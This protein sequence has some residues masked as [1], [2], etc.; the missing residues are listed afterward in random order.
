MLLTLI[1]ILA[2]C[3]GQDDEIAYLKAEIAYLQDVIA[4]LSENIA[5]LEATPRI[6]P[7]ESPV[8]DGRILVSFTDNLEDVRVFLG[9]DELVVAEESISWMGN[10]FIFAVSENLWRDHSPVEL[11]FEYRFWGESIGVRLIYY[12][13]A[14]F[15]AGYGFTEAGRPW[16]LQ[17]HMF[18]ESFVMRAIR[19]DS[20]FFE[21][22]SYVEV[23][24]EPENW[25]AQVVAH[26]DEFLGI[27]LFDV[28]YERDGR[29]VAD[30]APLCI[31]AP[32]N[33]GSTG[34]RVSTLNIIES[35]ATLPNVTEIEVL[36]G[37]QRGVEADHFSFAGVFRV[38][39]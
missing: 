39:N 20:N 27:R 7:D 26:F 32:W 33:W 4:N 16:R 3:G 22:E 29:L 17:D 1:L 2:A 28:W 10:G 38:K 30:L 15:G 21:I 34:G 11:L 5:Y 8:V 6:E 12:R 23:V 19:H 9:L 31:G 14:G 36:V 37:G 24:I 18:E 13:V 35:L 25:Q